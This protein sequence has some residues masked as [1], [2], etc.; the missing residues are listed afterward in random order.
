MDFGTDFQATRDYGV[1][2]NDPVVALE[3]GILLR[4]AKHPHLVE[5]L[6]DQAEPVHLVVMLAGWK[7]QQFRTEG[8]ISRH[9]HRDI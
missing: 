7:A 9:V 8:R 1:L 2:T 6:P 5:Q 3:F 4:R